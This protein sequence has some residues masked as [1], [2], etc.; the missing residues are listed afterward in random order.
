MPRP[1]ALLGYYLC[2]LAA[3]PLAA[4]TPAAA[5]PS[6]A[7]PA[8]GASP[9]AST[10]LAQAW[11]TRVR[12]D[13]SRGRVTHVVL[14]GR[15]LFVQND[16]AEV[17]AI[18][19]ETGRSLWAVI[20]GRP[21]FPSVPVAANSQQAVVANGSTLYALDR[22]TGGILWSRELK[23]SPSAGAAITDKRVYLPMLSGALEG[24]MLV[25]KT[26]VDRAPLIF[27]GNG[28]SEAPPL[29]AD[30]RLMWGTTAANVYIDA[31]TSSNNRVRFVAGGPVTGRLAYRSPRVFFTSVDGFVYA[32]DEA[33]G[34]KLWEFSA[35]GSIRQ[36]PVAIGDALYVVADAGG[37]WKLAGNT[38]A[39]VWF[40]PGVTQF[41]AASSYRIYAADQLGQMLVL[42]GA[43]GAR[44]GL[45][46][47]I[48]LPIK[49]RNR[50]ND[51]VYLGTS[52][53][54]LA[55][56][57]E[58]G[59][60]QPLDHTPPSAKKPESAM[61]K[62]KAATAPAAAAATEPAAEPPPANMADP[63]AK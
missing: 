35:G 5:P 2:L 21:D 12:L 14:Q 58:V 56:F 42:D 17:E 41:V 34:T 15:T 7:K 1:L 39:Q 30:S 22:S 32:I 19:S 6:T 4:Q 10:V 61:P 16:R 13:T 36:P 63:F 20:V 29:V 48:A 54:Y 51:R 44:Q 28:S 60:P 50:E 11:Q 62:K 47:T 49:Y 18:D 46:N 27:F 23:G 43:T 8:A 57:H 3:A 25:P 37:M 40:V 52:S 59:L 24:Y 31:L 55:C 53:G 33:R 26:A 38:G 9:T 45:F